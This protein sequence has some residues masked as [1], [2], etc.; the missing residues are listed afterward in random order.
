[1]TGQPCGAAPF[2]AAAAAP[3]PEAEYYDKIIRALGNR[4]TRDAH[5]RHV[6]AI[7]RL[8]ALSKDGLLLRD[9]AHVGAIL[10]LCADRAAEPAV[11][12]VYEPLAL[13]LVKAASRPFVRAHA[14]DDV[15]C[16]PQAI[17]LCRAL[18]HCLGSPRESV[19]NAAAAALL[20]IAESAEPQSP[21]GG[22]VDA[23]GM[24]YA[25]R[26]NLG[27]L[28]AAGVCRTAAELGARMDGLGTAARP[29]TSEAE[30]GA[31]GKPMAEAPRGP[32]AR[33]LLVHG[34]AFAGV[35][36]APNV[37]ALSVRLVVPSTG[38]F[39]AATFLPPPEHSAGAEAGGEGGELLSAGW[40]DEW[41]E[42][43]LPASPPPDSTGSGKVDWVRVEVL[44]NAADDFEANAAS[45][46]GGGGELQVM[47]VLAVASVSLR[48]GSGVVEVTLGAPGQPGEQE[49]GEQE[50]GS[51]EQESWEKVSG[52]LRLEWEVTGDEEEE[53]EGTLSADARLPLA[54]LQLL[55]ACSRVEVTI[56]HPLSLP[57][58]RFP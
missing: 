27:Y 29:T 51:Q 42:L 17:E 41:L 25:Q 24:G 35:P 48:G 43:P 37:R 39:T 21:G 18:A 54:L 45:A 2:H 28:L 47:K 4:A 20:F 9:L 50:S 52:A 23:L 3:H 12:P 56:A 33:A 58:R 8:L 49:S 32:P 34:L 10:R 30:A 38:A 57:L 13:G 53:G 16:Q 5:A 40:P 36:N 22:G 19:A 46:A 15:R 14:A 11:A 26:R 1:M 31:P 6:A 7:E 44:G 55:S